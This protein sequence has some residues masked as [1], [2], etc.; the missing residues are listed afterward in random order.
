MSLKDHEAN[1]WCVTP[2]TLLHSRHSN[3]IVFFHSQIN[4]ENKLAAKTASCVTPIFHLHQ[5]L[6]SH[7]GPTFSSVLSEDNGAGHRMAGAGPVTVKCLGP[8]LHITCQILHVPQVLEDLLGHT[9]QIVLSEVYSIIICMLALLLQCD[10]WL[11]GW[12]WW[13]SSTVMSALASCTHTNW[14]W[15]SQ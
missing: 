14:F 5:W 3:S 12:F 13:K 1:A 11:T 4:P 7:A 6:G 9:L 10:I 15:Y 2:A 8:W